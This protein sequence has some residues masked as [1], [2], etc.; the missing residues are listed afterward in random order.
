[1]S[2]WFIC[3]SF[4]QK[5]IFIF[6]YFLWVP[7]ISFLKCSLLELYHGTAEI[8]TFFLPYRNVSDSEPQFYVAKISLLIPC[9]WWFFWLPCKCGSI[10]YILIFVWVEGLVGSFLSSLA[11]SSLS[12]LFTS[13][14]GSPV[15]DSVDIASAI[16]RRYNL[17]INCLILRLLDFFN[18]IP[19]K[20]FLSF[21][22]K[23][24]L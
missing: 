13:P 3:C 15:D 18:P 11:F 6:H 12:S 22:C 24:T 14:L 21:R 19:Y 5:F 17:T 10:K 8:L 23:I 7:K 20:F 9:S 2:L 16:T 1:M 4:F